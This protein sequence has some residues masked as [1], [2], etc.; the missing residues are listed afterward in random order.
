MGNNI[1]DI[2]NSHKEPHIDYNFLFNNLRARG[3]KDQHDGY[4]SSIIVSNQTVKH[5]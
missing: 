4:Q 5:V 3:F 2:P 1:K